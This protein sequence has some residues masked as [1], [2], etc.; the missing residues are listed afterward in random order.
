MTAPKSGL[1]PGLIDSLTGHARIAQEASDA[2]AQ[3]GALN[4]LLQCRNE[5]RRLTCL[6]EKAELAD[7]TTACS[8]LEGMFANAP[9]ALSKSNV[10]ADMKVSCIVWF[11]AQN[12]YVDG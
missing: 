12:V 10:M 1:I 8:S 6:V 5:L 7:A 2:R 11:R 3:H 9:E 4:H